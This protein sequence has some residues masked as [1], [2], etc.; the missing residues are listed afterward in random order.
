[1]IKYH[2]SINNIVIAELTDDN[3][4]ISQTQDILDLIGDLVYYDCTRIIIHEKNLHPDFFNLKTGLAGDILQKFSNYRFKL[5]VAGDFSKY[6]SRSL[7][8]FIRESNKGK[9]IFF[10][11]SAESAM[12]RL[13]T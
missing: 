7:A 10:V 8:D 4:I 6:K 11:D 13:T 2:R 9:M 3:L 1:M 12:I 5:A